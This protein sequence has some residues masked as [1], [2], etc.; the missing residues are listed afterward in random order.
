MIPFP[1]NRF[2][3]ALPFLIGV[4]LALAGATMIAYATTWGPWVK[5]DSVEYVEAA[6]NLAVGKGLVLER[7]SGKVVPLSLRPPLYSLV[8]A[9]LLTL[10]LD[11]IEA[12]RF[13]AI[14]LI[15][16]LVLLLS[17]LSQ[18]T[19]HRYVLP[20]GIA[21]YIL[22][23]PTFVVASTGLMSESLFILLTLLAISLAVG[24]LFYRRRALLPVAAALA[25]L[26]MLTRFAG[27]ACILVVALV[28]FLENQVRLG[29]RII[30]AMSVVLI[31]ALPF[32][33]WTL[34][35]RAAGYSPGVYA[36]PSE[37]LWDALRPVRGAYVDMLWEWLP[38]RL[39]IPIDTY[40]PK[41]AILFLLCAILVW[42]AARLFLRVKQHSGS[43]DSQAFLSITGI[44]LLLF[45]AAH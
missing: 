15:F 22:T 26:A 7:A 36:L 9:G 32:A 35:V 11:A 23:L 45:A 18:Y 14:S 25:G 38:L 39:L 8:L 3:K 27:I 28:P 20:L 31:G 4:I 29:R 33:L 6:R 1:C 37:N 21:A 41:A 24:F 19:E 42:A 13:L 40:R 10:G 30:R 43:I 16:G 2:R 12:G 44:L 5:S 17:L 34:S